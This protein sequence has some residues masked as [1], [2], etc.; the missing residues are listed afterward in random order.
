MPVLYYFFKSV[1][2]W[3]S[4]RSS[5]AMLRVQLLEG[6][7][8]GQKADGKVPRRAALVFLAGRRRRTETTSC[9]RECR[10]GVGKSDANFLWKIVCFCE[11]YDI[12]LERCSSRNHRSPPELLSIWRISLI[13]RG[14]RGHQYK[15]GHQSTWGLLQ[16]LPASWSEEGFKESAFHYQD[17]VCD[18][19]EPLNLLLFTWQKHTHWKKVLTVHSFCSITGAR[20]CLTGET[21]PLWCC[22]LVRVPRCEKNFLL[23]N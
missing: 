22:T 21:H 15:V 12:R 8:Q 19:N 13:W 1:R 18:Q 10:P 20:W 7:S 16:T 6:W 23:P 17:L 3:A 14:G 9:L 2:W 11:D 5:T 4:Q